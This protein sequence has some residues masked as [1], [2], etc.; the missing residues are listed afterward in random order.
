MVSDS[1]GRERIKKMRE[2]DLRSW[3]REV[4][5]EGLQW[6]EAARGGT[7][8]QPDVLLPL[9][10]GRLPV[11]LKVW[12]VTRKGIRAEI[13]PAQRRYHILEARAGRRT[14]FL[15]AVDY[16]DDETAELFVFPGS[17]MPVEPYGR[18]RMDGLPWDITKGELIRELERESFW[19]I[20]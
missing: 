15:V 2:S 3:L 5:G 18:L 4:W 8:G 14:A 13:R 9:K 20:K 7:T 6:V 10:F 1:L 11:E 17:L 19:R 12:G 16:P